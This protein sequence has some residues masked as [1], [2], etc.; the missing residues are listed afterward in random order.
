MTASEER[1]AIA[2]TLAGMFAVRQ[3]DWS[4]KPAMAFLHDKRIRAHYP[5]KPFDF[6]E[7][8]HE[9]GHF[10]WSPRS[11]REGWSDRRNEEMS[12]R[13]AIEMSGQLR[14]IYPGLKMPGKDDVRRAASYLYEG[15]LAPAIRRGN[16]TVEQLRKEVRADLQD[17]RLAQIEDAPTWSE[18]EVR[19]WLSGP[20]V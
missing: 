1:V 4:D 15:Y 7:F 8:L 19:S 2:N 12:W 14:R 13:W 9:L 6:L 16:A 3:I 18:D 17:E 20:P 11:C 5:E 10:V